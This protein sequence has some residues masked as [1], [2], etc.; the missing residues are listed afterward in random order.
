MVDPNPTTP[1][2]SYCWRREMRAA[3]VALVQSTTV[4]AVPSRRRSLIA[5][6]FGDDR[7]DHTLRDRRRRVTSTALRPMPIASRPASS[8]LVGPPRSSEARETPDCAGAIDRPCCAGLRAVP[9]SRSC[10]QGHSPRSHRTEPIDTVLGLLYK[11]CLQEVSRALRQQPRLWPG[12]DL[13]AP[14]CT[15]LREISRGALGAGSASTPR[16]AAAWSFETQRPPG[17]LARGRRPTESRPT[18]GR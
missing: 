11:D 18:T 4:R 12:P 17:W 8:R 5:P 10:Q 9:R 16:V 6:S 13:E 7:E 15:R 3:P 14:T 2:D 1:G